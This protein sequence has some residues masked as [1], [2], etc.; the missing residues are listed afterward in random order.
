MGCGYSM[1]EGDGAAYLGEE[2]TVFEVPDHDGGD[3]GDGDGGKAEV[4]EKIAEIEASKVAFDHAIAAVVENG[5][6][7]AAGSELAT[8]AAEEGCDV[9][10][11]LFA[12]GKT[13]Q[14]QH[15]EL[16]ARSS[17]SSTDQKLLAALKKQIDATNTQL[18]AALQRFLEDLNPVDDDGDG[19]SES[20][21]ASESR[22]KI[23]GCRHSND[24]KAWAKRG[25]KAL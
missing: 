8:I 2:V 9:V 12:I 4:A 17:N 18:V 20:G 22:L 6:L 3:G 23:Y 21:A 1:E 7:P 19:R 13:L 16:F 15:A 25:F 5:G 24:G 14:G 10:G 11:A